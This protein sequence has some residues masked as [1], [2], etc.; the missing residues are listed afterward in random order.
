MV[1]YEVRYELAKSNVKEDEKLD[2]IGNQTII[3][4]EVCRVVRGYPQKSEW[5]SVELISEMPSVDFSLL[6]PWPSLIITCFV[7]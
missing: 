7:S 1:T 6:P 2:L 3:L 5:S 4:P